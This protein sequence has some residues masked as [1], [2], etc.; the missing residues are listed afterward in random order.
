MHSDATGSPSRKRRNV[1]FRVARNSLFIG[2]PLIWLMGVHG[3]FFDGNFT[4]MNHR[5]D[6]APSFLFCIA[7]SPIAAVLSGVLLWM[8]FIAP[9]RL[10]LW[11][12]G[13]VCDA[14]RT[15]HDSLFP[16]RKPF[17]DHRT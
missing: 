17:L 6:D 12:V 1:L 14:A 3:A 5:I 10:I 11:L 16:R 7:I 13:R 4:I 2:T 8:L 15:A 9:L